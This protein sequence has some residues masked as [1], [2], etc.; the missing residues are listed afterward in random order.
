MFSGLLP[1][2][3]LC[4]KS[5]S[6]GEKQLLVYGCIESPARGGERAIK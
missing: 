3:V 4:N 6:S 1:E 5:G 2:T